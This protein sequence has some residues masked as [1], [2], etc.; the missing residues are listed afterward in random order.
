M[1]DSQ[2]NPYQEQTNDGKQEEQF[3]GQQGAWGQPPW[4]DGPPPKQITQPANPYYYQTYFPKKKKSLAWLW[5]ILGLVC[6]FGLIVLG[7]NMVDIDNMAV[8]NRD[9]IATLHIQGTMTSVDSSTYSQAYLLDTIDQLINDKHNVGLMLY[10]DSPGGEVYTI[11]ELY[12][13]LNEYKLVTERPIY[14]YCAQMAAS[15]GYYTAMAA[16]QVYSNRN[17][18]VGSIGVIL[19]TY[20]DISDFLTEHGIKTNTFVSGPN[21]GMGSIYAEMTE[22]HQEIVQSLIDES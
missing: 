1:M 19:G 4:R 20:I 2:Q 21:K 15:G 6:F 5:I 9:Y 14:A 13:K 10:I 18:W 16:E 12:M 7:L 11:D 22:E 8:I 17:G 3:L